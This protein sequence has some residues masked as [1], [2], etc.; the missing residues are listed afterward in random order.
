VKINLFDLDHTLIDSSHR[1]RYNLDGSLDI[2]H[3]LDNSIEKEINKDTLIPHMM[4]IF[5]SM[6]K[7][8]NI[9]VTSRELVKADFDYLN[10]NNLN[11]SYYL[12]RGTFSKFSR[13]SDYELKD[14]LLS[15]ILKKDALRNIPRGYAF[16]D[17]EHN[18]KVFK[19]HEF[20]AI[21]STDKI[22]IKEIGELNEKNCNII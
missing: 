5:N 4:K 10:N 20:N 3:W 17:L 19:K 12:H 22:K 14:K 7:D 9:C 11:F 16:D 6:T 13:L 15:Y 18:L 1:I 8:I 21:L 2:K